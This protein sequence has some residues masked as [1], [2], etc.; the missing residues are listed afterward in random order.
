[1]TDKT[2]PALQRGLAAVHEISINRKAHTTTDEAVELFRFVL[3][4]HA[5]AA[6]SVPKPWTQHQFSPETMRAVI[7]EQDRER[8]YQASLN[9]H[10]VPIIFPGYD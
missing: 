3:V 10:G 7:E 6:A 8:E 5:K 9:L 2:F 4:K 1:M